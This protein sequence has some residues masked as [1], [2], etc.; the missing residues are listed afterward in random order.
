MLFSFHLKLPKCPHIWEAIILLPFSLLFVYLN[1]RI[2]PENVLHSLCCS[3][4][5]YNETG[6][7]YK[8]SMF[9]YK[10]EF[11][12]SVKEK[13]VENCWHLRNI[14]KFQK[15][16]SNLVYAWGEIHKVL[17]SFLYSRHLLFF[18]LWRQDT[19]RGGYLI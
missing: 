8:L 6:C 3:C 10:R 1:Y 4:Y 15:F 12:F 13:I 5:K 17:A 9:K 16:L 11:K 19:K 2:T 14:V 7:I 18:H